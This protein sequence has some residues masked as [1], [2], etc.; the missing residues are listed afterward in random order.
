MLAARTLVRVACRPASSHAAGVYGSGPYRGFKPPK[1]VEWHHNAATFMGTVA[2]L[3]FFWRAK[4][5][6]PALLGLCKPWDHHG[7]HD[8]H[9]DHHH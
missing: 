5:D 8:D 1:R 4:H 2:W 3:W 7:D 6:G 9:D